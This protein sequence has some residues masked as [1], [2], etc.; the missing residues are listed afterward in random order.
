MRFV[1]RRTVRRLKKIIERG[2]PINKNS[3]DKILAKDVRLHK[4][5]LFHLSINK[6]SGTFI[7]FDLLYVN[8]LKQSLK[9]YLTICHS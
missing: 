6:V 4:L 1:D 7:F 8:V 5:Q 3:G 9:K 2:S